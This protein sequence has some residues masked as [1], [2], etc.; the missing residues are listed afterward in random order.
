MKNTTESPRALSAS[1]LFGW[2]WSP[3]LKEWN[4]RKR[5]NYPSR[6]TVF[7]NGVW[8]TWDHN[9]TGGENSSCE[10]VEEAKMQA[11]DSASKQGFLDKPND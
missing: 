5:H 11:Q 2:F 8:H 7:S 4:L 1:D 3:K 10:T 9:G 6:A